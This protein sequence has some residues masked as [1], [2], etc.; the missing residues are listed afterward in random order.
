MPVAALNGG[1]PRVKGKPLIGSLPDFRRDIRKALVDGWHEHGDIVEFNVAG[2]S[3]LLAHPDYIQHILRD[4]GPNYPHAPFLRAR[5]RKIVGDGLVTS[6]SLLWERQRKLADPSFHQDRIAG[7]GRIMTETTQEMLGEWEKLA[8]RGEPVE[9]RDEMMRLTIT[10]LSKAMFS[11]DVWDKM[12]VIGDNVRVLLTHASNRLFSPIDPPERIPLPS[13]KRFLAAQAA[14]DGLIYEIIAERRREP[15]DDLL[16]M[17]LDARDAETGEGMSDIQVRDEVRTMF[18][19]G[20]ETTATSLGWTWYLLSVYPEVARRLRRELADVLGGRTPTVADLPNLPYAWRVIQ[21]SLRLY[22]PIWMYLRTAIADDEIAGYWIKGGKNIYVSPYIV[23]RHPD[24]YE[25]PEA[26]DPDRF[27]PEKTAS[28]HRFQYFPFGGG[29]RKCIGN[30]FAITE[31]QLVVATVAQVYD[32]EVAPGH[33]VVMDPGLSLR[34]RD[35]VLMTL[36]PAPRVEA[37]EQ[38]EPEAVAAS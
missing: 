9:M 21:E 26:F 6:K 32:P 11:A 1:P 10:I 12:D 3:Y 14:F 24:F 2:P 34:P 7:F 35:G 23:H 20:H 36:K 18:I 29:P 37:R 27:E 15:K 13:H 30:S 25:N 33:A 5:W 22:P 17:F 8:Q 38:R 28:W 31:M 19:A 4:N 16:S